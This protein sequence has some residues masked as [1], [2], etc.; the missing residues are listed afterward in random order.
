MSAQEQSDYPVL[1]YHYNVALAT[2]LTKE[3]A[4]IYAQSQISQP[5]C[6]NHLRVIK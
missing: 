1:A 2:G 3:R 5:T 6:I 4:K